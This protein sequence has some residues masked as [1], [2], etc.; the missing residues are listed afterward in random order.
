MIPNFAVDSA[1]EKHVQALC[2]NGIEGWETA[3]SKFAE[4]Q[5]RK[6][7]WKADSTKLMTRKTKTRSFSVIVAPY[8]LGD[9]S[10]GDSAY[11]EEEA[12]SSSGGSSGADNAE[13]ESEEDV[14][15]VA[16]R[17]EQGNRR[18]ARRDNHHRRSGDNRVS[19]ERR[20]GRGGGPRA[21]RSRRR[22][23]D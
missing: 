22:R 9:S 23:R 7:K 14:P 8:A 19:V 12:E 18:R 13:S 5:T 17:R 10:P 4:W 16:T 15:V 3:G 20:G 2:I 11:V 6:A 1:V 21:R